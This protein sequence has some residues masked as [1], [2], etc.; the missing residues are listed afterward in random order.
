MRSQA[1]SVTLSCCVVM[2]LKTIK[3]GRA[4]VQ[5]DGCIMWAHFGGV[6]DWLSATLTQFE[7]KLN[8]HRTAHCISCRHWSVYTIYYLH[9]Y[10]LDN[11]SYIYY[12][13]ILER[14]PMKYLLLHHT[15]CVSISL[16]K[17]HYA[18]QNNIMSHHYFIIL[19]VVLYISTFF[20]YRYR[21][22]STIMLYYIEFHF[23][24]MCSL[25][26]VT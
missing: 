24:N 10:F 18:T 22:C 15:D 16:S 25:S 5:S 3:H 9:I 4:T 13:E 19:L 17:Y 2:L 6:K 7:Q 8:Q 20:I 11:V 12:I 23:R 26:I 21:N 14:I 1:K